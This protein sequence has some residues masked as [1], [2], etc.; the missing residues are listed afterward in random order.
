M[1]T[2][3][4]ARVPGLRRTATIRTP[5]VAPLSL[6]RDRNIR[7]YNAKILKADSDGPYDSPSRDSALARL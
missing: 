3:Y 1:G 6:L 5:P 4:A 7:P 2:G